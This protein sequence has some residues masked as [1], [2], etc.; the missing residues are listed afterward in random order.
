MGWGR[1]LLVAGAV[2]V[3]AGSAGAKDE[4]TRDSSARLRYARSY[5]D[6]MAEACERGCVVFATI[7]EDG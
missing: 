1:T 3:L 6:A 7:H 5:A 2:A 4:G